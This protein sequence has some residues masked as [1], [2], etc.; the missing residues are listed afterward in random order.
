MKGVKNVSQTFDNY[1]QIY[2]FDS[3]GNQSL[4]IF[5]NFFFKEKKQ[6]CFFFTKGTLYFNMV[7]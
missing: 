4:F 3:H 5:K 1:R 2:W 7:S 6:S